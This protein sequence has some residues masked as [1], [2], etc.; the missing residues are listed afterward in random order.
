[1]TSPTSSQT[2]LK[3][4]ECLLFNIAQNIAIAMPAITIILKS[5]GMR[6]EAAEVKAKN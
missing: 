4:E 2:D 3:K 6:R 1:M 5:V